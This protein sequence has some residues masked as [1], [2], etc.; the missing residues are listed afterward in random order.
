M[1]MIGT[2]G[3]TADGNKLQQ[4]DARQQRCFSNSSLGDI[5]GGHGTNV[6]DDKVDP[7]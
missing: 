7:Q 3:R 5:E 6:A 4:I 2:V 1:M